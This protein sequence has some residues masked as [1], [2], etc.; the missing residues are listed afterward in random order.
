MGAAFSL[1][2]VPEAGFYAGSGIFEFTEPGTYLVS[3]SEASLENPEGIAHALT[4][5]FSK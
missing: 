2:L 1:V 3:S 5:D 4:I